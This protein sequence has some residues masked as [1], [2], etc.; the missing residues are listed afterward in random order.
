VD[1]HIRGL[2]P[3]PGAW[4]EVTGDRVKVLMSRTEPGTGAPGEVLDDDLLIA[5][6][7]GAVRLLRVQRAGRGA[8]DAVDFL[9]GFP[10]AA[11]TQLERVS[12]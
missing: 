6:G 8:A 5:C 10:V 2:S 1:C 11:G 3:F 9:R 7:D 4:C 12:D